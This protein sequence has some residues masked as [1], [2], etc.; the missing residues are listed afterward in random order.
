MPMLWVY[1][2]GP[3]RDVGVVVGV[4]AAPGGGVAYYETERGW[5]GYL[6]PCG[7]LEGAVEQV[8]LLLKH[9][10]FPSTW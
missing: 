4:R 10:M 3:V 2:R 7:E 8:D 9:R 6:L 1:A 5:A